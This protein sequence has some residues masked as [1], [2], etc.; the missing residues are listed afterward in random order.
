MAA[1]GAYWLA[2]DADKIFA[3]PTT[4]TGSIGIFG[5]LP[6]FENS[7]ARLGVKNDGT[8]TTSLAGAGNPTRPLPENFSAAMQARVERGYRKFIHIVA[9]GRD[10]TPDEVEKIAEGRVW[11][12]AAALKLGLVDRMG[13]LEDAV[14][15]AAELAGLST[16]QGI[17]LRGTESPAQ[18]ILKSIGVAE[19]AI[20]VNSSP[21]LKFADTL[22]RQAVPFFNFP[23]A[24]D[25]QNIYAY[26]LLPGSATTFSLD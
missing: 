4:L 18:M 2:A 12:G 15:A 22:I 3:S 13:T 25:P 21:A 17:Y 1:S 6:T 10:M 5:A 14:S 26:C 7:L 19:S 20:S 9:T 8:G 11:D 23:A 16:D 24:R